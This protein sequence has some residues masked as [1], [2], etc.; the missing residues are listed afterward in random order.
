MFFTTLNVAVLAT[1]YVVLLLWLAIFFLSG[2]DQKIF[3]TLEE[4]EFPLK[5]IYG[6]GYFI[7]SM[8]NYKYKSKK[9]WKL[10]NE[11]EVLYDEKY[12]DFYIRVIHAQKVTIAFFIFVI[13]FII[14][15]VTADFAV[16]V[17][18]AG[19][20]G[21]AYYYFGEVTGQRIKERSQKMIGDFA[22]VV[23][24]LALLTNA[25]MI[26]RE[27]WEEVAFAGDSLLYIEMQASVNDMK[28]GVSDVE[29]I[30]QFGI[31]CM[32]SEI[33]KF[34]STIMQGMV[35]GNNELVQMLQMQSREVW[36]LRKQDIKRQGEKAATKL[37][38]P[39]CI[40]FIGILIMILVPIFSN[41]GA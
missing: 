28:N 23:S 37:L 13:A 26:L 2:K 17:I 30:K 4:K 1:G 25:G 40:M 39:M 8:L 38:L 24:K 21:L 14:Y 36:E 10:R 34:T 41:I 33:K 6:M 29:A 20:S 3:E 22:E 27:A 35:K 32:M 5:D 7:M 9:D 18:M 15:G 16:F 31:R 19:F 12:A 11:V